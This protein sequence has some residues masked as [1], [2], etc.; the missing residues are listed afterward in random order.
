M[1]AMT[2]LEKLK[3][4]GENSP[5]LGQD[6]CTFYESANPEATITGLSKEYKKSQVTPLMT[7][8]MNKW[9]GATQVDWNIVC[10]KC[11]T[12]ENS[13]LDYI[14]HIDG[15]FG[16]FARRGTNV[17]IKYCL[18]VKASE[19][20]KQ[21]KINTKHEELDS[22]AYNA[23]DLKL[24]KNAQ[25]DR[26]TKLHK[27]VV[28][29]FK[30]LVIAWAKDATSNKCTGITNGGFC[31]LPTD[32]LKAA[33]HMVEYERTGEWIS[34]VAIA[35]Q[36][37]ITTWPE[38]KNNKT[39]NRV[40]WDKTPLVADILDPF[41]AYKAAEDVYVLFTDDKIADRFKG[42]AVSQQLYK[43]A[44]DCMDKTRPDYL[45][46]NDEIDGERKRKRNADPD[47]PVLAGDDEQ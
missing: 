28:D 4:R 47:D 44:N 33:Y 32:S 20:Y 37:F 13:T 34:D 12:R 2:G 22:G 9:L 43:A 36:K 45:T 3:M 17:L 21:G 5:S 25:E 41:S 1:A 40:D 18:I 10:R 31:E 16:L 42:E 24:Y 19:D 46:K 35:A 38:K 39:D 6:M 14:K 11:N 7:V 8:E 27:Q 30:A 26:Y 23:E 29:S 15:V